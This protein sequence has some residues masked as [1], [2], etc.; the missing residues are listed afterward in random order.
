[1]ARQDIYKQ[2]QTMQELDW[3]CG[4]MSAY[5]ALTKLGARNITEEALMAEVGL[6]DEG[7]YWYE[8]IALNQ[9]KAKKVEFYDSRSGS[10]LA[11]LEK[12]SAAGVTIACF[13]YPTDVPW[14]TVG[15]FSPIVRVDRNGV[16]VDDTYTGDY[17]NY[18]LKQFQKVWHDNEA[19]NAFIHLI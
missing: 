17:I 5:K 18:S 11:L 4:P 19:K 6:T 15:H 1:M 13:Q 2:P 3:S 12:K 14:E 9:G 16:I 7:L 10:N 8:L